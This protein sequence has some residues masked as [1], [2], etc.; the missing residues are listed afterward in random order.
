MDLN[1]LISNSIYFYK[2]KFMKKDNFYKYEEKHKCPKC[3]GYLKYTGS[4]NQFD[5]FQ[6][7]KCNSEFEVEKFYEI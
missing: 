3:H 5:Q 6:C 7:L 4:L 1:I 2:E